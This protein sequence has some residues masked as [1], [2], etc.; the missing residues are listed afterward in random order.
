M[1]PHEQLPSHWHLG[2]KPRP[3]AGKAEKMANISGMYVNSDLP[4]HL[5]GATEDVGIV[6]LEPPDAC[7]PMESAGNFIAVQDACVPRAWMRNLSTMQMQA[8]GFALKNPSR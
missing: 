8:I 2:E 7:Q 6:L 3:L 4:T 5:V 1:S